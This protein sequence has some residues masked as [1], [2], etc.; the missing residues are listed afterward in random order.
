M[1]VLGAQVGSLQIEARLRG[2]CGA[3]ELDSHH[4]PLLMSTAL[5]R[6]FW[7]DPYSLPHGTDEYGCYCFCCLRSPREQLQSE[8][9]S[10]QLL[11]IDGAYSAYSFK[12][13]Y[14]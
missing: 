13:V 9:L 14:T 5:D 10:S 2:S 3:R 1:N 11:I 4:L 12:L 7:R 8:C 6:V